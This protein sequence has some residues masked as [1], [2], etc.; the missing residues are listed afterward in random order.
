MTE[1]SGA[2]VP[3]VL[4]SLV[5]LAAGVRLARWG[6]VIA[7][8]TGIGGTWMGL[9]VMAAVTSLP[10]LVTGASSVVL[11]GAAD[12]AAG[13]A[14][15]SCMFNLVVLALLDLRHPQPISASIHQGHVLTAGFGMVQLSVAALALVAGSRAPALGWVGVHSLVFLGVWVFAVRVVFI[16][17][18][19]RMSAL[20]EAVGGNVRHGPVSLRKALGLYALSAAALVLA[21]AYLPS[22]A[23]ALAHASGLQESFVGNLFVATATSLPELVVSLA[24]ARLGAL[25]MAV[26]NLFGSN[27]FN[28][29]VLG[30][31][32]LLLTSG[33]MFEQISP[34]HLVS[35]VSALLMTAIA[36]IGM[37][38]RAQ[39]KRFRLSWDTFFVVG[40][41]VLGTALLWRLA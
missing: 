21:A 20:A 22:A 3:F 11:F 25:D 14:I 41:Y 18:R 19:S 35:L 10:E 33:P 40:A 13:D 15:G 9:V 6:D 38:Y 2:L 26:A 31:D 16:H 27:V 23:R 32:D 8:K 7:E 37:T 29:A 24:A 17:E 28:V 30:I 34:A 4:A 39:R 5:I 12:L 36:V 1:I